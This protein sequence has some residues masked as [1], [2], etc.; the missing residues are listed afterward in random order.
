MTL[1][2]LDLKDEYLTLIRQLGGQLINDANRF[3][4]RRNAPGLTLDP[5]WY[6]QTHERANAA[7]GAC[8]YVHH[9]ALTKAKVMPAPIGRALRY[10]FKGR[11]WQVRHGR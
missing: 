3:T 1:L 11:V 8:R 6:T 7:A 5:L 10:E 4:V 9:G 2:P